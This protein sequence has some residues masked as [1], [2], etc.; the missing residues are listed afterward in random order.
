[1]RE[2]Q[3]DRAGLPPSVMHLASKV[4]LILGAL[5]LVA[6]GIGFVAGIGTAIDAAE[7]KSYFD[8]QQDGSFTVA[9]NNSWN[10]AV[11][12]V[13]P[14]D[15]DTLDLTI[16]DSNGNSVISGCYL[17]GGEDNFEGEGF[18]DGDVELYGYM[19]HQTAGMEYTVSSNVDVS[20]RGEYCDEACVEDAIGGGLAAL[21]GGLGI[22][23]S[24][25]LIILGII[26]ALVLDEPQKNVMMPTGHMQIGQTAYQAPV[27]QTMHQAP[28]GQQVIQ[29]P[30]GQ[31]IQPAAVPVTPITPPVTQQPTQNVWDNQPP[32]Q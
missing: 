19:D 20:I 24:I 14:V 7:T 3:F 25:P 6:S 18:S 8:N 29:A 26:L 11:Y 17:Y 2:G 30:V 12:V 16:T 22:C 23:C 32:Q 9:E 1:M 27:Q 5:M 15:C 4:T 21:G 10:V 31:S 28:V 13:H